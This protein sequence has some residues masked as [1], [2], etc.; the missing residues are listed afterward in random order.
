M[1]INVINFVLAQRLVVKE[2]EDINRANQL[3]LVAGLMGPS[4][5]GAVLVQQIARNE[6]AANQ[7]VPASTGTVV[8]VDGPGER[9]IEM[10]RVRSTKQHTRYFP[11]VKA[12]LKK[13]GFAHVHRHDHFVAS[14]DPD[15][16]IEQDP[17]P[18]TRVDPAQTIVTLTVTP[19]SD[20]GSPASSS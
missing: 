8:V 10:P 5:I 18:G 16:V 15:D 20:K 13:K 3:A 19:A 12:E 11:E 7:P 14:A 1:D 4:L 17:A 6:V 9:F 2:G